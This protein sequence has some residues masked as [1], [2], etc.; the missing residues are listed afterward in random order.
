MDVYVINERGSFCYS[1]LNVIWGSYQDTIAFIM[2]HKT[3]NEVLALWRPSKHS[4]SDWDKI[5]LINALR[6]R[7]PTETFFF[8]TDRTEERY[9]VRVGSNYDGVLVYVNNLTTHKR[10][11]LFEYSPSP[12]GYK[13]CD[14]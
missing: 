9:V 6:E 10:H 11:Y 12:N 3:H 4:Q 2:Q 8:M 7:H 14:K 5:N 1:D 13:L